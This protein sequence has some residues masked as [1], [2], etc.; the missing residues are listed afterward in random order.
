MNRHLL[1]AS[2]AVVLGAWTPSFGTAAV[3][4]CGL[5]RS[6]LPPSTP[7]VA[8]RHLEARTEKGGRY[9]WLDVRT[10]LTPD[11]RFVYDVLDEGGS[12]Q[13]RDRALTPALK[14]EQELVARGAAVDM[15]G[16]LTSYDCGEPQAQAD[17]LLRVAIWPRQPSKHLVNGMLLMDPRS[18]SVLRVA[19]ALSK[20][21]SFWVS[22][23]EMDWTY[24]RVAGV[25]LPT[26]MQARAK[27]K[28]VGPSTFAMTYR[29]VSV[30]GQA[31]GDKGVT[32]ETTVDRRQ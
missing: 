5:D 19:G 1:T 9:G 15:P 24:A 6:S 3:P 23:V 16:L 8:L 14:R 21:P 32:D 12:E 31:V 27:V 28:F 7:Y 30:G 17:G 11:G 20:S 13:V 29:Y 4:P 2:A 26:A 22:D 18:G 25:V 10:T